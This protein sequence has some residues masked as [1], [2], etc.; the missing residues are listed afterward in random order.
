[1]QNRLRTGVGTEIGQMDVEIIRIA[2]AKQECYFASGNRN[3]PNR[4]CSVEDKE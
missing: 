1:M 2:A 4:L 3:S